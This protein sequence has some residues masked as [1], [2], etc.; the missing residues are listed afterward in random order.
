MAETKLAKASFNKAAA[1]VF[2]GS[3]GTGGYSGTGNSNY[4]VGGVESLLEMTGQ[5]PDKLIIPKKYHQVI[6]MCYD[7]YQRGGVVTTVVN[8][9]NELTITEIR[10]GQRKTS[11]EANSYYEAVLHRGPS[12]LMRFMNT[13][14]LEYFLSGLVIPRVD[15][16]VM[17]GSEISPELKASRD[18]F[19]PVFDL[20]PPNLIQ[21]EWAGWGKKDYYL[22]IPNEDLKLIRNGGSSIKSQQLRYD[23]WMTNYPAFVQMVLEG[24]DLIKIQDADP[25]LRKEV[26]F[27]QYPT[28]FLFNCLEALLFKQQLRR[29]DFAVASRVISAILLVQEGDKD[30]P[31]SEDNRTNLDAL[32]HQLQARAGNPALMERLFMLFTN[33]TTKL[34]WISPDI[35]ALLNQDK[36]R[37]TNEELAQGLGFAQILVTGESRNAQASE[38]STWAI[39]P[40]MEELRFMMVEW[41]TKIYEE[42]ADLNAFR[43]VP[44]PAFKPIQLQDFVKTAAVM[45]QVFKEGNMS[46]ST[47]LDQV[48]L[49]FKSEQEQMMDEKPLIDELNKGS[50]FKDMPYNVQVVPGAGGNLGNIG[51]PASAPRGGRPQGSQNVPVNN[52]NRGVKPPGQSPTSRVAAELDLIPDEEVIDLMSKVASERGIYVTPELISDENNEN[53]PEN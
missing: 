34:T 29:M 22:K 18:Y 25:I 16:V 50:K 5:S 52:R 7:F 10:N 38:L 15:W 49:N 19:M 24:A 31:I 46:R 6:K 41:L 40:Q 32:E 28:P 48:G 4:Y 42:A 44:E 13:M 9:L 1:A 26:S 14:G 30:F 45:A 21:V 23:M 43:N 51:K 8:R 39:K 17:K 27:T 12:R 2:D 37:E 11:D 33:H 47:R 35:E 20:Y 36:Y 3:I 53:P